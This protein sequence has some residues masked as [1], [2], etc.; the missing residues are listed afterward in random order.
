VEKIIISNVKDTECNWDANLNKTFDP[1]GQHKHSYAFKR[2]NISQPFA[3]G[4]GKLEVYFITLEPGKASSPFH[5]HTAND[6][7]FYI[8]KGEGTLK[9]P[10]GEK[11]VS[12]GDVIIFPPHKNGAH[13]LINTS[14]APIIYIDLKAITAPGEICIQPE[15]NKFVV[16]DQNLMMKAYN[17]D[18]TINLLADC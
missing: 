16:L 1:D 6:E 7:M 15:T 12:E 17:I 5:Y 11:S 13:M 9:T 14:D 2:S 3:Q 4:W 10:D 8:I 18:S